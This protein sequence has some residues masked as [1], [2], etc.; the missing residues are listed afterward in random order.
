MEE[1]HYH[2]ETSTCNTTHSTKYMTTWTFYNVCSIEN[3]AYK[4]RNSIYQLMNT[5][6]MFTTFKCIQYIFPVATGSNFRDS[7]DKGVH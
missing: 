6:D 3:M 4:N 5:A 7:T 2:I 1:K